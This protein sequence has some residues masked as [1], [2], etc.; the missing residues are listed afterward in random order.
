MSRI[1]HRTLFFLSPACVL[2]AETVFRYLSRRA[3]RFS[4]FSFCKE[5][6]FGQD[7]RLVFVS[8]IIVLYFLFNSGFMQEL[9]GSHPTSFSLGF[10]R[11]KESH[12][13]ALKAYLYSFYHPSQ[14]I[15]SAKWFSIYRSDLSSV[16]ADYIRSY[17]VLTSYGRIN[18]SDMCL[19]YP[20]SRSD[21]M[22]MYFGHFNIVE[23]LVQG[24]SEEVWDMTGFGSRFDGK[25]KLYSNGGSEIWA[26]GL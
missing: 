17:A 16:S 23:N 2:G 14:D 8:S 15:I 3:L 26:I 21:C 7:L 13:D 12:D 11:M 5:R 20:T 1:Y 22:Y 6:A 18:R 25:N 4:F 9:G 24:P 10:N 19:L